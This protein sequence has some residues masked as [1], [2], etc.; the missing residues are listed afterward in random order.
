MRSFV[1]NDALDG[2]FS[3]P[4]LDDDEDDDDEGR[5]FGG[6]TELKAVHE[7]ISRWNNSCQM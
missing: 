3:V 6:R 1:N 2:S 4:L 5:R 7:A